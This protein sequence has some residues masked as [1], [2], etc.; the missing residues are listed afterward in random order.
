M[1][2]VDPSIGA[3]DGLLCVGVAAFVEGSKESIAP[4]IEFVAG[5]GD[6]AQIGQAL[7]DVARLET[8]GGGMADEGFCDPARRARCGFSR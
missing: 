3:L 4:W 2:A 7:V 5:G 1:V 8:N 6:G